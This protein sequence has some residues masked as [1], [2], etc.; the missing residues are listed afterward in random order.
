[1]WYT[2]FICFLN[3]Y[4]TKKKF[5]RTSRL[6]ELYFSWLSTLYILTDGFL[7]MN[8]HVVFYVLNNNNKKYEMIKNT[9]YVLV[10]SK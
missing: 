1:M 6:I 8:E 5:G 3:I 4:S 7:T 2:Q 10:W 9:F